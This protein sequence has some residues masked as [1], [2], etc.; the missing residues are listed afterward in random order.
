ML[1]GNATTPFPRGVRPLFASVARK[2]G[3]W[4]LAVVGQE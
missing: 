1:P 4:L 2:N 3:E